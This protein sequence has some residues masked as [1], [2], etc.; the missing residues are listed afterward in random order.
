MRVLDILSDPRQLL[1]L[2]GDD[3]CD[4]LEEHVEVADALLDVADLFLTLR[5][6]SV[7]KVNLVLRGQPQFLLH[8]LLQLLLVLRSGG[9]WCAFFLVGSGGT[10]G[11]DGGPLFFQGLALKR[12]EFVEVLFELA[13]DLAL[14]VFLCGLEQRER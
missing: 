5:D 9:E 12:L 14:L 1:A 11:G 7:L 3:L 10:G 13:E 2:L 6:Q 4:L 8:L